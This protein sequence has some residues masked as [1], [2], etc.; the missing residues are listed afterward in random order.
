MRDGWR[1]LQGELRAKRFFAKRY[2]F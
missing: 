2:Q 1:K